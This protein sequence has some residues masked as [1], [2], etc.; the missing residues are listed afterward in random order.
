M[1]QIAAR[2]SHSVNGMLVSPS[3]LSRY[4]VKAPVYAKP[5]NT[6]VGVLN[7]A[8]SMVRCWVKFTPLKIPAPPLNARGT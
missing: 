3:E 4:E 7:N 6:S 2:D 1:A 5:S 8:V